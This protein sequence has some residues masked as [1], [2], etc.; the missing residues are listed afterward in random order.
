MP[1]PSDEVDVMTGPLCLDCCLR[2]GIV[3][4]NRIS[5]F[6]DRRMD[7]FLF[8]I[9]VDNLISNH[10]VMLGFYFRNKSYFTNLCFFPVIDYDDILYMH[11]SSFIPTFYYKCK[12]SDSPRHSLWF[13]V[14]PFGIF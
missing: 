9:Y 14:W 5:G 7:K 3:Q 10:K 11:A 1:H 6:P 12:V 8:N 2:T 4:N 13:V